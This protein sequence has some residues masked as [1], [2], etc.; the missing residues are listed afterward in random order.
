MAW[1]PNVARTIIDAGRQRGLSQ[2][3]IVAALS[4]GLVESGLQNISHGDR[5]SLGVFQ[6]RP[7]QGWG[8][9]QQLTDVSYAAGKFY[10]AI[11]QFDRPGISGAE[12]AARIQR[13][14]AQ[15]RGRYQERWSEAED[16]Y[17]QLAG[18]GGGQAGGQ[19]AAPEVD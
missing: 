13:P 5:D 17:R 3:E 7:S 9:P 11:G 8:T 4:T 14:A 19:G 16:I 18:Q 6:Q 1:D 15:Y 2:R 10:D 12:L